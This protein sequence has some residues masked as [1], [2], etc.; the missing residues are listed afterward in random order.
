MAG[1]QISRTM[2]RSPSGLY[3]VDQNLF[4]RVRV[5]GAIMG[6]AQE[7]K[8]RSPIPNLCGQGSV[9]P[10]LAEGNGSGII[11]TESGTY[12]AVQKDSLDT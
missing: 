4:G 6:L 9:Q 10:T 8:G 2:A 5:S 1:I 7:Q 12:G 11:A 3:G